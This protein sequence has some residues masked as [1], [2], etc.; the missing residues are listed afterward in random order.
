M[1]FAAPIFLALSAV[2]SAALLAVFP[3]SLF[4]ALAQAQ[5]VAP[6][7]DLGG[8]EV[9]IAVENAYPPLQFLDQSGVAVGWEYEAMAE[10]AKRLNIKVKYERPSM[11]SVWRRSISRPPICVRRC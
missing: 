9:V 7:P 1:K 8:R 5:Q 10:M 4:P 6:L 3:V 11:R 2:F